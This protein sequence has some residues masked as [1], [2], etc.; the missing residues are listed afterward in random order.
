MSKYK[1]SFDIRSPW[2]NL[3]IDDY[4]WQQSPGATEHLPRSEPELRALRERLGWRRRKA[5]IIL[6]PFS[7]E[8]SRK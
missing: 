6:K 2:P 4:A 1:V 8:V 5:R 3:C 7:Q